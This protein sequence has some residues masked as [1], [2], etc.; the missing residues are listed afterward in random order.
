MDISDSGKI[1]KINMP[2]IAPA[3]PPIV[4]KGASVPPEVPLPKATD[5]ERNL[6]KNKLRIRARGKLPDKTSVILL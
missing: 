3:A 2:K 5:H 4:N 6:K 1:L